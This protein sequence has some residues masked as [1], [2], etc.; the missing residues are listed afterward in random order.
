ME[1]QQ[2]FPAWRHQRTRRRHSL[3]PSSR[4]R[5]ESARNTLRK[6]VGRKNSNPR[7]AIHLRWPGA[8]VPLPNTSH[9]PPQA[10]Y[11]TATTAQRLFFES[12]DEVDRKSITTWRLRGSRESILHKANKSFPILVAMARLRRSRLATPSKKEITGTPIFTRT[13]TTCSRAR[14]ILRA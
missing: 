6:P 12:G 10:T 7:F 2:L 5:P 3:R 9:A 8:R 11:K 14:S 1:S 4:A 13:I